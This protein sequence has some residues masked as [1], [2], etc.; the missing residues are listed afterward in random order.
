MDLVLSL[1]P[2]IDLLGRGFEDCG[3]CVVRGPDLIYGGDIRSFHAPRAVFKGIIGGSPCQDFSRARR[4]APTG[5]G[6][7]MIAEYLRIVTEADPDWF[8]LENV[9]GVPSVTH[10]GY[11]V[12]RF[13][14]N[15]KEVGCAQN[16]LR[17]FQF[18][19][20]SGF[21]LVIHRG[22]PVGAVSPC[23]LASEGKSPRRGWSQFCELQGLPVDFDLPDM[24]RIGKYR[25]VGN[26][27]PI[28]MARVVATA[29]QRQ[30]V[31]LQRVCICNCGRP[32]RPNQVLATA[33]CRK[34]EQRRRD[35]A[36][37]T[38]PGPVTTTPAL[39]QLQTPWP[40]FL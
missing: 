39:S 15:A 2:G 40:F 17:C 35:V 38:V 11:Q 16:R 25:A 31:T 23:V 26:G 5:N 36:A 7:A 3:Y 18:G 6:L 10:R 27:V 22:Q 30:P 21:P 24:S 33:A 28:P 12:Q 8:L 34:R 13:N 29:I 37:V 32:V 1:F 9:P 14:L 4:C 19:F 20:K